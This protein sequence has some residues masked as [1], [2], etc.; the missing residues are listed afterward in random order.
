LPFDEIKQDDGFAPLANCKT[1]IHEK[2]GLVYEPHMQQA[3]SESCKGWV[4]W[5]KLE[6]SLNWA[7]E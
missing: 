1:M 2:I 7:F 4:S 3:L 6:I 5:S